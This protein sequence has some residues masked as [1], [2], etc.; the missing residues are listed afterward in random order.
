MVIEELGED[1]KAKPKSKVNNAI[2]GESQDNENINKENQKTHCKPYLTIE[3]G[4]NK[5]DA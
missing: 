5:R 4:E 1:N 2:A 3:L